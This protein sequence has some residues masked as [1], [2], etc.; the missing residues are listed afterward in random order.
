MNFIGIDPGK[1]GAVAL[2][3][4]SP[5][6]PYQLITWDVATLRADARSARLLYDE[7]GMVASL[8]EALDFGPA[9]VAIEAVHAMPGQG[10]STMFAMGEGLGLWKGIVAA[11][12][13]PWCTVTPQAWQ[14]VVLAGYKSRQGKGAAVQAAC[15]LFSVSA[16]LFRTPR[17]RLLDGR[18]DAACIA[19]WLRRQ[20]V[21]SPS[22]AAGLTLDPRRLSDR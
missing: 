18:A 6:E 10:V 9:R 15:H 5:G 7:A 20:E 13:A 21:R 11:L 3:R 14:K 1:Q 19:E 22:A 12:G 17:G 4:C 2:I 16:S 8:H